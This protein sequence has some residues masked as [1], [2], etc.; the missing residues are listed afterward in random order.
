M[1]E[2]YTCSS[3]GVTFRKVWSDEEAQAE[4]EA[5]FG[6][7]AAADPEVSVVCDDCY[8]T[9]VAWARREGFIP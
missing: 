3:C 6:S 7:D 1:S 8:P 9:I 2:T 4:Y 5:V